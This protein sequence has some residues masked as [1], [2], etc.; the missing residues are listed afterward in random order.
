MRERLVVAF[1]GLTVLVVALY[2][3]PR[4]Y[5]LADIVRDQEHAKV[6]RSAHLIAVAVV[7]HR[8]AGAP[9][10]AV[11]LNTLTGSDERIIVRSAGGVVVRSTDGP[12]TDKD[13]VVATASIEGGGRVTVTRGG[14]AVSQEIAGAL[15]PLVALGLGLA[16]LAGFAGLLLA[17]R[18][19]RPFTELA[20]AARAMGA[21]RLRPSLPRYKVPEARAIAT[22]LEASGRALDAT[23]QHERDLA[24]HASHELRTPVTALRLDLEDLALWPETPPTI[25]A[26]IS[27][28]TGELDRLSAAIDTLLT[29]AQKQLSSTAIDL[30]LD[31]LV[32]DTVSR[33]GGIG[34]NV[35]Y[36]PAGL[37]PTRL[38]PQPVIQLVDELVTSAAAQG[39]A[40]AL[41]AQDRG[42]HLEV[43]VHADGPLA[44]PGTRA[45]DLAA[46]VGGQVSHDDAAWIV[47]L[48]KHALARSGAAG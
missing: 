44:V 15:L 1:V 10:D 5:V 41:G 42:T 33:L 31:V 16:V 4:A 32:A 47:R 46:A 12:P 22:A 48:P 36:A 43:W 23:L 8:A 25:G 3:I 39:R 27:R 19:S 6:D 20:E 40:V 13:D 7:D 11:Y 45:E 21:G 28:A 24:V 38:D 9:V 17:R 29:G 30:D 34:I 35:S 2:G 26:E 18:L 14:D 37:L